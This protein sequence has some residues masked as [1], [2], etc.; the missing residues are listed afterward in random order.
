MR[1]LL[2]GITAAAAAWLG[3]I[4]AAAVSPSH[5]GNA[6]NEKLVMQGKQV[7]RDNCA[8]CHGRNLEGQFLWQLQ[9]QYAHR[10]APAHDATGHTWMHSDEDLFAMTKYGRFPG[11]PKRIHSYM[12]AFEHR[13]GDGEIVAVVAYI[14]AHWPTGIRVSQSMLNPHFAGMPRDA[15][16][17]AWTLPPTCTESYKRWSVISR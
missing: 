10:R 8:S 9:D 12:P 6:D 7:Y 3:V 4:A 17:V 2:F 15:D 1:S 13:L 5:F 14:K 16:K 11:V